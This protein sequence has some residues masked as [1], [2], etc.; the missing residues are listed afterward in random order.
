[1]KNKDRSSK[2]RRTAIDSA[3]QYDESPSHDFTRR[4]ILKAVAGAATAAPLIGLD[5]AL[6]QA[7]PDRRTK[8]RTARTSGSR[9]AP[10]FFSSLEL[11]MVDELTEM[12]IPTDDHSPGARAAGVA[13]FLD[14]HLAELNPRLPEHAREQQTWRNGLKMVNDISQQMHQQ[15]FMRATVAERDAV[16]RRMAEQEPRPEEPRPA[17]DASD[18]QQNAQSPADIYR[19]QSQKKPP[20][21]EE[22]PPPHQ[23]E[24]EF[25]VFLKGQTARVYYRSEIGLLQEL[26]YQGNRYVQEFVGYDIDGNYTKAVTSDK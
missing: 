8:R 13:V 17:T 3:R 7:K 14:R 20:Q 22:N 26:N 2:K 4:E 16:L 18:S 24:G 11:K 15:L 5:E 10:L 1:M 23:D 21:S 12:I 25:F 9:T 19:Q 6:G